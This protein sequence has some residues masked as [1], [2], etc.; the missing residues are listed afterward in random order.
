M[1]QA[2]FLGSSSLDNRDYTAAR[3]ATSPVS[4]D[5]GTETAIRISEDGRNPRTDIFISQL[6]RE[7]DS[8]WLMLDGLAIDNGHLE[9]LYNRAVDGVTLRFAASASSLVP[10][11]YRVNLR[12]PRLCICP[13]EARREPS[14]RAAFLWA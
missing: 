11:T 12:S 3:L 10:G 7:T 5:I 4:M 13:H 1:G 8:L 6:V 9:M 14:S 2:S